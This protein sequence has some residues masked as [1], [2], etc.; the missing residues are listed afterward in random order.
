MAKMKPNPVDRRA[1]ICKTHNDLAWEYSDGSI[2]CMYCLVVERA[3]D[4]CKWAPMPANWRR[5]E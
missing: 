5:F 3:H 1:G 4:D 2:S